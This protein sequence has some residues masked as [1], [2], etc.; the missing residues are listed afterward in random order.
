MSAS[1]SEV[2]SSVTEAIPIPTIDADLCT[3]CGQCSLVCPV[4]IFVREEGA[5]VPRVVPTR[6]ERCFA[7]GQC[8]AACPTQAV[9]AGGLSYDRDFGD[10]PELPAPQAFLDLLASRRSVRLYSEKP[11]PREALERIAEACSLAPMSFPPHRASLTI[12]TD[13]AK[14]EML[15]ARA[16]IMYSGFLRMMRNRFVRYFVRRGML[17]D[18]YNGLVNTLLPLLEMIEAEGEVGRPTFTWGARAMLFFHSAPDAE[19]VGEDIP[20]LQTYALLAAHSLGLGAVTLGVIPP[21]V[22]QVAEARAALG[23]PE[24]H[25]TRVAISLGYPVARYARSIRRSLPEVRWVE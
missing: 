8:M 6:A 4:L 17:P 24:G 3:G 5:A 2:R 22:D 1:R 10:L 21:V 15:E 25:R 16:K 12:V 18:A 19:F 14:L 13:A 9:Q 23:I 20:I 7:C 11:V